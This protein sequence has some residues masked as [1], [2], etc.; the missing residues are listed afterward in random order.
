MS[1]IDL[2]RVVLTATHHDPVEQVV[3][4]QHIQ[5]SEAGVRLRPWV[6]R[7]QTPDQLDAMAAEAGLCLDARDGGWAGEPFDVTSPTHVSV[8]RRP[9]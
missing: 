7:Y 1:R 8:Y 9:A 3:T 4:G 5:L 2:D 6:V